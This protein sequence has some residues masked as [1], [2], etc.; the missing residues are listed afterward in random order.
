[1]IKLQKPGC[2]KSDHQGQGGRWHAFISR[3]S[4]GI[5]KANFR[6]LGVVY[7]SLDPDCPELEEA[8]KSGAR[9]TRVR[10]AMGF[11]VRPFG[12]QRSRVKRARLKALRDE[13][14]ANAVVPNY[15]LLNSPV[16]ENASLCDDVV[17]TVEAKMSAARG[18]AKKHSRAV[19]QA[20]DKNWET[21]SAWEATKGAEAL[22]FIESSLP[23][24]RSDIWE[25]KPFPTAVGLGFRVDFK[26]NKDAMSMVSTALSHSRSCNVQH[27]IDRYTKANSQPL[28]QGAC[29]NKEQDRP[30]PTRCCLM[31]L[32]VCKATPHYRVW[33]MRNVLFAAL[34]RIFSVHTPALRRLFGQG[35]IVLRFVCKSPLPAASSSASPLS[36][37]WLHVALMYWSPYRPTFQ[38]VQEAPAPVAEPDVSDNWKY[39]Q[40]VMGPSNVNHLACSSF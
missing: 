21:V 6:D 38:Q 4:N 14:L 37:L 7:R 35:F 31:R 25:L 20:E 16:G 26:C 34:K 1:V 3:R 29:K 27:S 32:C 12:L 9:A 2:R 39:I 33:L 22:K 5:C 36:E 13:V 15:E 30:A 19:S 40:A 24:M 11:A 10:K 18:D 17:G 28:Q 8:A 23:A